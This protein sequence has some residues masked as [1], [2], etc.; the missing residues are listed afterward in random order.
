MLNFL[1]NL[2]YYIASMKIIPL[3]LTLNNAQMYLLYTLAI[4]LFYIVSRRKVRP[5]NIALDSIQVGIFAY[6]KK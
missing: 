5:N 2:Y 4:G 1:F 6:R 3:R